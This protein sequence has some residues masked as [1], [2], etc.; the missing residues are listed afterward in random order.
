MLIMYYNQVP[1]ISDLAAWSNYLPPSFILQVQ[2]TA[3]DLAMLTTSAARQTFI[4]FRHECTTLTAGRATGA[5]PT[6]T[7]MHGQQMQ[8]RVHEMQPRGT[9]RAWLHCIEMTARCQLGKNQQHPFSSKYLPVLAG[10]NPSPCSFVGSLWAKV[11]ASYQME[12][13][14]AFLSPSQPSSRVTFISM[15]SDGTTWSGILKKSILGI[16]LKIS[17]PSFVNIFQTSF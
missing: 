17:M 3:L 15:N 13:R 8:M 11:R 9:P 12:A 1:V 2:H 6:L 4:I 16:N 10:L 7:Q 14:H 5:G